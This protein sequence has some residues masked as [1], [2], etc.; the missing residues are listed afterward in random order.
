MNDYLNVLLM[1]LRRAAD[2]FDL[3]DE[4]HIKKRGSSPLGFA[5]RDRRRRRT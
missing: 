2:D 4:F 3:I 5:R 1:L